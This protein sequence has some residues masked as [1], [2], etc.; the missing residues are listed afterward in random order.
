MV[1]ETIKERDKRLNEM[2]PDLFFRGKRVSWDE[3]KNKSLIEIMVSP[4]Y[5][6]NLPKI[7][8]ENMKKRG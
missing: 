7:W 1:K 5:E 3:I 8:Q 2:K 4:D 6:G